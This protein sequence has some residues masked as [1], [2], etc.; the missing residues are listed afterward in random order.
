[1]WTMRIPSWLWYRVVCLDISKPFLENGLV[2][3][4]GF[5]V[6]DRVEF[7]ERD[8]RSL[9]SLFGE[10]EF[11]GIVNVWTTILGYYLDPKEDVKVLMVEGS[12]KER[13]T[14][15][16]EHSNKGKSIVFSESPKLGSNIPR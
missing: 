10:E 11:D 1:M 16:T 7:V 13:A 2:G 15:N 14:C 5:G 4:E 6:D 9:S 12:K 3:Q 8:V